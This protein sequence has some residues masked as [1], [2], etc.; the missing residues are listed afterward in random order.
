M[1]IF[2]KKRHC[3]GE[4]AVDSFLEAGESNF[5][6]NMSL[7][8]LDHSASNE[9]RMAANGPGYLENGE[10]NDNPSLENNGVVHF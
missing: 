5:G 10:K 6:A 7:Y 2:P 3:Q 8:T 1:P 4:N 9:V